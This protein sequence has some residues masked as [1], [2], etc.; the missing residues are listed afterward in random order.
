MSE[1]PLLV[2]EGFLRV[3]DY[4]ERYLHENENILRFVA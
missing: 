2:I 1:N 3:S 4:G